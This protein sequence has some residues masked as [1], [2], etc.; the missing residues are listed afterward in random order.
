MNFISPI[1]PAAT[2]GVAAQS[3][4]TTRVDKEFML[5]KLKGIELLDIGYITML[6]FLFGFVFAKITDTLLGTFD[7]SDADTKCRYRLLL[8]LFVHL[9]TY[10][11][12]LYAVRNVVQY[13]PSP[14]HRLCSFDHTTVKELQ[15]TA[16]FS[17][18]YLTFTIHLREKLTYVYGRFRPPPARPRSR[19]WTKPD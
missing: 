6:Y 4:L 12:A 8:E 16:I 3:R 19:P 17:L 2:A 1:G 9:W 13:T 14:F 10:G 11:I 18:V 5:L 15:S 7:P